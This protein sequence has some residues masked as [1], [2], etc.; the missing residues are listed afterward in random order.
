M[1]D[2]IYEKNLSAI[3]E[4]FPKLK[5]L[6]EKEQYKLDDVEVFVEHSADEGVIFKVKKEERILYLNGKREA[7]R[8]AR[9]WIKS[10]G[11]ISDHAFIGMFGIGNG[12]YLRECIEAT[13]ESVNI[14][15][16]EPSLTIFLTLL[17]EID[18]SDLIENRPIGFVVEGLNGGERDAIF[19]YFVS[20]ENVG[21]VKEFLYPNYNELYPEKSLDFFKKFTNVVSGIFIRRN[22]FIRFSDILAKNFFNNMTY[23]L[24][25]Y[26]TRQLT[27]LLPLDV[28]AILVASGPSL[29][30]NMHELKKAKDKAFIIVVDSAVKPL[31][32]AGIIPDVFVTIDGKKTVVLEN[33]EKVK[34]IPLITP[35]TASEKILDFHK[36]KK[37]FYS[38]GIPMLDNMFKSVGVSFEP[39]NGGG[40]VATVGFSLAYMLGFNTIILVGQDLAFTGNKCYVDGAFNAHEEEIDT[41]RLR[42]VKGNYEDKLPIRTDMKVYL[43]WYNN[44][45]SGIKKHADVKVINATEGGAWI[46]G[47]EIMTLAEAIE[48][49]CH[50][51]VNISEC[52]EKLTPVFDL[53]Q[54][55][56]A[57]EYMK[58][59][60]EELIK[61][62]GRIKKG[63]SLYR[64]LDKMCKAE[65]IKKDEYLILLRKIDHITKEL[66]SN[67]LYFIMNYTLSL[68]DY[69]ITSQTYQAM[70]S[71]E[72]EGIEIA[73]QG[74][75]YMDILKECSDVLLLI[76]EESILKIPPCRE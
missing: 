14:M 1:C 57:L 52:L 2:T 42:K 48:Q 3:G 32:E 76:I 61:I 66:Q 31:M 64:R 50:K 18:I 34:D 59:L 62:K 22:T 28:P 71:A 30:K 26:K 17:R 27:D 37:I 49:E 46:E 11:E 65:S 19:E 70:D 41:S 73:R 69:I 25:G 12:A 24:D 4:R 7:L 9:R 21:H 16:Y 23:V 68:A 45:I 67:P 60:P 15:A 58:S 20:F 10:L 35:V 51:T 36:G 63:K 39:V 72:E 33:S 56:A 44:Y 13:K 5:D 74:M 55:D 43:D 54:R 6:I 8:P 38:E 40:S 75:K 29:N 53:E 47:T